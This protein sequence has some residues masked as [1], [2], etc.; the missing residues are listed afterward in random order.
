MGWHLTRGCKDAGV[1]NGVG[2]LWLKESSRPF[3]VG[4]LP[5]YRPTMRTCFYFYLSSFSSILP[6]YLFLLSSLRLN[7]RQDKAW[8][9]H[10][11]SQEARAR[12]LH[13]KS[14]E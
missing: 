5:P 3:L 9:A 8:L 7:L 10:Q 12:E 1:A 2:D 13:S 6:S 4:Y 14:S 11:Q